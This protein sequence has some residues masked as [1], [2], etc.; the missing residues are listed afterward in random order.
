[1][2]KDV[3]AAKAERDAA[4]VAFLDAEGRRQVAWK[5][6]VRAEALLERGLA[7]ITRMA[8]YDRDFW[9]EVNEYK[10]EVEKALLK[11]RLEE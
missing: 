5:R 10:D 7:L 8:K 6:A 11:S 9:P 4:Q 2:N 3:V 1:M